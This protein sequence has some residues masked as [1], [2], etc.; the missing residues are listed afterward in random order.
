[1]G[2]CFRL[3]GR[4][5]KCNA[6]IEAKDFRTKAVFGGAVIPIHVADPKRQ[7]GKLRDGAPLV[8]F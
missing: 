6:G 7:L 5:Q 4:F 2:Q 1:M 3:H 8:Q